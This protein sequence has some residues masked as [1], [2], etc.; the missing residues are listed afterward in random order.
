VAPACSH[1]CL[2]GHHLLHLGAAGQHTKLMQQDTLQLVAAAKPCTCVVDLQCQMCVADESSLATCCCHMYT[3]L[4]GPGTWSAWP[5]ACSASRG[6]RPR[7]WRQQQRPG[8]GSGR[9]V[10]SWQRLHPRWDAQALGTGGGQGLGQ[11]VVGM[12]AAPH[13]TAVTNQPRMLVLGTWVAA[14]WCCMNSAWARRVSMRQYSIDI[15]AHV[16]HCAHS[17]CSFC[18]VPCLLH[19][20]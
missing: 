16:H 7:C 17:N 20:F 6:R 8:R 3:L 10:R 11:L 4:C 9:R 1:G 19:S 14:I 5:A 2:W 12:A 13:D 15:Y 18:W